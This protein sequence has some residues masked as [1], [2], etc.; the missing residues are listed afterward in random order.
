MQTDP[1]PIPAVRLPDALPDADSPRRRPAGALLLL[2]AL[3]T[4]AGCAL[5][6]GA[7][8]LSGAFSIIAPSALTPTATAAQP[9]TQSPATP[10]AADTDEPSTP[11][12]PTKP[13]LEP[14]TTPTAISPRITQRQKRVL[15][16]FARLVR[17][18]YV[19]ADFNGMTWDAAMREDEAR[20]RKGMSDADFH[21]MLAD[22]IDE[23]GDEHSAY[24]SP[25]E[26]LD[27][28]A[29]YSGEL[30]YA[31]IGV[32]TFPLTQTDGLAVLQVF[33]GSPAAAAGIRPHDRIVA[34]DG[35]PAVDADGGSNASRF[36]GEIGTTVRAVLRAPDG[37]ERTVEM[38]RAEVLARERVEFRVLT[39]ASARI[40]YVMIPTLF[41]E[42]ID[43]QLREALES[44]QSERRLDGLIIDLRINGGGAL[45]VL[46]PALGF[47]TRGAIGSLYD[48]SSSAE[49]I[50]VRAENIG[51]SQ[52]MPLIVLI[53]PATES[54]AEVF[55]G[56]LR[57][58]RNAVLIGQPTA[59][60]IETLRSHEFEDG[61]RLW[62]AE[63]SFRLPS[64]KSWE[65]E[66]L[67]PDMSIT[68]QWHEYTAEDDPLVA[69]ALESFR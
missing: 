60:N 66:G 6:I 51:A 38:T 43:E 35:Q 2:V 61:S 20:V 10:A 5:L 42:N 15:D 69:A 44:L 3:V 34:I 59:G 7:G 45:D 63:Q 17:E 30:V 13:T 36:R 49:R 23:L 32:V 19:Y 24:L 47:F 55:A 52:S 8:W 18:R 1:D 39:T 46:R 4:A 27:E 12:P 14:T 9:P 56:V 50:T 26:A 68:A 16:T 58:N 25:A 31:G 22:R 40:G 65:G 53:G 67:E 62:L 54:Y 11:L 41:E 29:E 64:G 21:A 28:D 33:E 48:R 57:E 37:S